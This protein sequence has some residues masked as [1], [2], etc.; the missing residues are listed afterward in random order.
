MTETSHWFLPD[1]PDVLGMLRQQLEVTIRGMDALVAWAGG[2]VTAGTRVRELEH[3]ADGRKRE[4][5]R[6]LVRAFT[7]PYDPEDL[8]TLCRGVD[9]I[10]NMAKDAV[11][12]SE[13]MSCPPDAHLAEMAALLR[14]GVARIDEAVEGLQKRRSDATISADEAI[15]NV[16]HIERVYREAMAGLLELDDLREVTARRELYRRFSR[17]GDALAEVAERVWYAVIKEA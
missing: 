15:K 11:R 3:E 12:E 16:R 13:V 6:A 8:Y 14:E 2:D 7:T 1:T 10:L 5:Q 17:L 9:G 4:L